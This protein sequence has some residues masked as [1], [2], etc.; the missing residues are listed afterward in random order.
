M[1]T[2]GDWNK[3]SVLTVKGAAGDSAEITAVES[4]TMS[5][6]YITKSTYNMAGGFAG[7]HAIG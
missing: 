3:G 4:L 7:T 6:C 1:A 5:T 2:H